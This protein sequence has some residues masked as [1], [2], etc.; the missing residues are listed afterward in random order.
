[1]L[2]AN[3]GL[4]TIN[5]TNTSEGVLE[6]LD[7]QFLLRQVGTLGSYNALRH[8]LQ[9]AIG[10]DRAGQRASEKSDLQ[11]FIQ[12]VAALKGQGGSGCTNPD[13]GCFGL[14]VSA[15]NAITTAA[16]AVMATL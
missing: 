6:L 12:Q 1:L 8:I 10:H 2:Q 16:Q 4:A 14:S 5:S 13:S 15:A 3:A 9:Q 11:A 7:Q